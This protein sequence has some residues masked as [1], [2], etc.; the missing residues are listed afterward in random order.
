MMFW[1]VTMAGTSRHITDSQHVLTAE[2]TTRKMQERT[3]PNPISR[4]MHYLQCVDL[5]TEYCALYGPFL[6][7]ATI[8]T[9]RYTCLIHLEPLGCISEEHCDWECS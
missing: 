9:P 7:N 8:G 5:I 6:I 4:L 3:Y 1:D 2:V